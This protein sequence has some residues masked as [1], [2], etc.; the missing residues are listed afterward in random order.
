MVHFWPVDSGETSVHDYINSSDLVSS[1]PQFTT[2]RFGNANS[3]MLINSLASSWSAPTGYYFGSQY[4]FTGWF[5]PHS[6]VLWGRIFD[7]GNGAP[8]DNVYITYSCDYLTGLPSMGIHFGTDGVSRPSYPGGFL[9]SALSTETWYHIAFVIN[10]ANL[11]LY[12]DG[13]LSSTFITPSVLSN[14]IQRMNNYF[15][16]S[17]WTGDTFGDLDLDD[18]KFFNIALTQQQIQADK[19]WNQ[20]ARALLCP[21]CM[22]LPDSTSPS[23]G[24]YLSIFS[25]SLY[26][27]T[28]L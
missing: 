28:C 1:S 13:A 17:A 19:T 24:W 16:K 7:F 3:A 26:L 14:S 22:N 20:E 15:G 6:F 18:L 4:T 10:N 5:R 8:I 21:S 12:I 2:D 27:I 9:T 23:I 11:S 25:S